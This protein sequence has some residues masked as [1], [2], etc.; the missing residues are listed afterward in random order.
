MIIA[1]LVLA[2]L[3]S[4]KRCSDG[5][6]IN[7]ANMAALT[8]SVTHY[9]NALGTQT[10][11]MATLQLSEKQAKDLLLKKDAQLAALVKEFAKI[12]TVVKYTTVTKYDS[13]PIVYHDTVPCVFE[14]AGIVEKDWY[15]FAYKS[16]QGGV[17]LLNL[18][19]PDTVTAI[20]GIKRKW[21][22]GKETLTTDITNANPNV[23]VTSIKA[24]EIKVPA[25]VYKKWWVWLA[26]GLAGGVL[27]K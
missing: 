26:V 8:D 13:I 18:T 11:S 21:F 19:V 1:G 22:L 4:F 17:T 6:D 2:L 23:T 5:N 3:F 20:T 12:K 10:A 9:K 16:T 7:V 14:R 25:P 24:A 15:S 27:I